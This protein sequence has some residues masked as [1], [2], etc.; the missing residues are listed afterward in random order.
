MPPDSSMT[1]QPAAQWQELVAAALLGT[2]RRPAPLPLP[3]EPLGELGGTSR[4][5]GRGGRGGT[6][7]SGREPAG[8]AG[9]GAEADG[10]ARPGP[11]GAGKAGRVARPPE[12]G[13]G[14]ARN[15]RQ[16]RCGAPDGRG[17]VGNG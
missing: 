15:E 9:R 7:G 11:A 8:A 5:A 1:R 3:G 13:V 4:V 17:D 10:A 2:E 14:T 16:G 12:P 6:A